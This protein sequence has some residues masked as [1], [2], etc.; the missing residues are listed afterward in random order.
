M[1]EQTRPTWSP[2]RPRFGLYRLFISW[3]LGAIALLLAAWIVPH[4]SISDFWGGVL[5]AAV[6]AVLNAFLPPVVA[7]L[8]LPYMVVLGFL[9]VLFLDAAMLLAASGLESQPI[10]VSGFWWALPDGTRRRR[11]VG[12]AP[13]R[14]RHERRRH[15]R[16]P[17]DPA[18]RPAPGRRRD[19]GR[20][21]HPLSKIDGLALPVLQRA[22]RDGNAPKLARWLA[23]GTHRLAEWETDF[24][25]QTG[26]ASPESCSD[27]TTTS[28]RSV[29]SRRRPGRS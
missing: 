27:R 23:Q 22:L 3:L 25:S 9:L 5:T 4:V 10:Q 18:N 20:A 19:D 26:Q 14:L 16:P 15:L 13:D 12:A 21:R 7:A 24:S 28:P 1:T 2:A 6:I 11:G 17:G 29:G 8:R